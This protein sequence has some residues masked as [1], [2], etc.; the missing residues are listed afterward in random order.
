M[1]LSKIVKRGIVAMLAGT[2]LMSLAGCGNS[3]T[4]NSD[5]STEATQE[6]SSVG[7]SKKTEGV[8]IKFQQWWG[9]ELP[10]GYLQKICDDYEAATGNKVELL[11]APWA[12]TKTAITA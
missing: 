6:K 8:T 1:K 7:E 4:A 5:K 9:G 2:M 11:T 12:D 3:G 10:D